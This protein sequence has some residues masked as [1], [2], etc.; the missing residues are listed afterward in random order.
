MTAEG[1]APIAPS[2]PK[3]RILDI[4]ILRGFALFGVILVNIFYFHVPAPYFSAYYEQFHDP[5]NRGVFY[6][7]NWFFT[8]KFYPIFSFLFGLGFSIQFLSAKQ[9][10]VNPYAFLVRRL[11]ILLFF[12]LAHIIF[13]WEEDILFIYAVF[14]FVLLALIEQSP[15]FILSAALLLYFASPAFDIIDHFFKLSSNVPALFD[16]VQ[17]YADFYVNASYWQILQERLAIYVQKYDQPGELISLLNRLAFFLIGLYAGKMNYIA[18]FRE[19]FRVWYKF[20]ILSL[21]I[22]SIGFVVDKI[23]LQDLDKAR[24]SALLLSVEGVENSVSGL[25]QVFVYII[26][27]LFLLTFSRIRPFLLPLTNIGRTALTVYLTHTIVFSFLFYSFGLRLYASLSPIQLFVIAIVLFFVD[28]VASI[29]W[30]R[31]YQYG[32]LEWVWRSLTYKKA[33]PLRKQAI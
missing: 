8:G 1:A 16:S 18:T 17:S 29:L 12:G 31:Y 22:F 11:T 10:G 19:N 25:F 30:L 14:G 28:V 5:L 21:F 4:D 15:T 33:L 9:K 6:I 27:F 20:L 3:D 32:P 2:K 7:L 13:V 26:G 23:W 24:N